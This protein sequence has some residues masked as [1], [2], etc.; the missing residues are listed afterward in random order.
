MEYLDRI[1]KRRSK[2][3]ITQAEISKK[4]GMAQNNY[5]KLERGETEMSVKRLV[6][7]AEV[8]D[9]TLD[10]LLYPDRVSNR[11]FQY[12]ERLETIME[13]KDFMIETLHRNLV[14]AIKEVNERLK[15]LNKY[16]KDKELHYPQYPM[17]PSLKSLGYQ[18]YESIFEEEDNS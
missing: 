18:K 14:D 5:G 4:L 1:K 17:I 13:F 16:E 3:G 7:I 6:E 11:N 15:Q 2:L 9:V 10:D 8:L 12:F